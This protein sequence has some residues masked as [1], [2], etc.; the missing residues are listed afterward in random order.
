[1]AE[2]SKLYLS[3]P[4]AVETRLMRATIRWRG[5]DSFRG[6]DGVIWRVVEEMDYVVLVLGL[7]VWNDAVGFKEAE[8]TPLDLLQTQ[9]YSW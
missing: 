1:M 9:I 2:D 8:T 5:Q 4:R 7:V 3:R 6:Q